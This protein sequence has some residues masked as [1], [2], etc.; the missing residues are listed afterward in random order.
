[1]TDQY[2][3][4]W[5]RPQQTVTLQTKRKL[6]KMLDW[7]VQYD[8]I[9]CFKSIHH[10]W[11]SPPV[12]LLNLF[13]NHTCHIYFSLP[14]K[15]VETVGGWSLEIFITE[16]STTWCD[17]LITFNPISEQDVALTQL[18]ISAERNCCSYHLVSHFSNGTGEARESSRVKPCLWYSKQ[19]L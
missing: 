17:S 14:F 5:L 11:P 16:A 12:I 1:M 13:K 9:S 6:E 10:N 4:T 7:D 15:L 3:L 19:E 18:V 2:V 8:G